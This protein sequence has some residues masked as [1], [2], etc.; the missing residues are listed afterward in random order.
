MIEFVEM[1]PPVDVADAEYIRLL[2]FPRGHVLEGRGRELADWARDWYGAHGRPGVYGR[3]A[4]DVALRN[5]TIVVDATVFTSG[6]LH[7]TLADA[8]AHAVVLVAVSAG[9]E[10]ENEAR[11]AWLEEKPDEYFF[12][13][14]FGSAVVERLITTSGA[15]LCEQADAARMAVLP[16]YSPGYPDWDIA[17]QS[18]LFGL[19][20]PDAVPG[21]IEVFESGMLRP[22]KS[23]LAVFGLTRHVD[24][25]RHLRELVPCE[26]CS[27]MPCQFRRAPYARAAAGPAAVGV[28]AQ[29]ISSSPQPRAPS[30]RY[31]TNQSALRRWSADRL[32]LEAASDGSVTAHFRY[33]GTTCSNMG[34]PLCFIY[35]VKLGPET[36]GY[37]ILSQ[38]CTPAPGDH[39]HPY[40]CEYIRDSGLIGRIAEEQPLCGRPLEEVL[41]WDRPTMGPACFCEADGRLHK[42]GLVLETIHF[43][44]TRREETIDA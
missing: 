36:D 31:R 1:A 35:E 14:M 37:R 32:V 43:A 4:S 22:K 6:R 7:R 8:D 44:L 15:R 19:L 25:V 34:R 12:L 23:L 21:P 33:D 18:R 29:S 20:P 39:G 27:F 30:L 26:Q 40:M 9:P 42:W 28:S 24:R 3:E 17:D 10:L 41:A 38:R 2:G 5:G 11:R 13:E 16:H